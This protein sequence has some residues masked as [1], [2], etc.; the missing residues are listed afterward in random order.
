MLIESR[1]PAQEGTES[2]A[3]PHELEDVPHGVQMR[4]CVLGGGLSFWAQLFSLLLA[5]V[6]DSFSGPLTM[7]STVTPVPLY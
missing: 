4:G 7:S 6:G 1:E 5:R 3:N 2:L